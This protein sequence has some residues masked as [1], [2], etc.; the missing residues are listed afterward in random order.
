MRT[1][2]PRHGECGFTLIELLVG[3]AVL[4]LAAGLLVSGLNI[5]WL[6]RPERAAAD[7]DQSVVAAQRILRMRLER[8]AT[9]VRLDTAEPV[10]DAQGDS[11]VLNFAAAPLDRM[12][13]DAFQRF[14]LM[15]APSGELVLFTASS[16]DDRIDLKDRSLVGWQPTRLLTG[17]SSL[18]LAYY[19][20]DRFSF[21][22]RWQ[23]F[24]TDRPQPPA[25]I[26]IRLRFA[27]GDPRQWP[28]LIVRPRS[29]VNVACRINRT[30]GRCEAI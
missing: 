20:P 13:P 22:D 19:G 24:W 7:N 15:L 14:R 8:L 29:T 3:L 18:E 2:Y 5:A 12:G 17:A 23:S 4:S 1:P 25:L 27:K 6:T 10:V 11:K 21:A 9:V 30:S 28:D 16:L 26:R